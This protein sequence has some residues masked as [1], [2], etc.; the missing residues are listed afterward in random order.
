MA[1]QTELSEP[2][3]RISVLS[4]LRIKKIIEFQQK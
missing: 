1:L 3:Q 4:V 2:I